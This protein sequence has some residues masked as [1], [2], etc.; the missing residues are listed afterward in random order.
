MTTVPV[1]KTR[2]KRLKVVSACGECR[3]KKTKCNGEKPCTGCIRAKVE[4]KYVTSNKSRTFVRQ[5]TMMMSSSTTTTTSSTSSSATSSSSNNHQKS[6]QQQQSMN[7][8]QQPAQGQQQGQGVSVEA[9]EERLGVIED[10]LKAL[11]KAQPSTLQLPVF[12]SSGT[13]HPLHAPHSQ[14]WYPTSSSPPITPTP[15]RPTS[16]FH[17]PPLRQSSS[18][19]STSSSSS[20]T[21]I[22]NLLNDDDTLPTPPLTATFQ[23]NQQQQHHYYQQQYYHHHHPPPTHPSTNVYYTDEFR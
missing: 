17:L 6:M 7:P 21:S 10:I 23:K 4:C 15:R 8:H 12:G 22:R 19:T 5:P 9:I 2:R 18:T 3:R 20:C 13:Y 11:L 16:A 1:D 14:N